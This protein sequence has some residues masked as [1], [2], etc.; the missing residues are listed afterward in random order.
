MTSRTT[1]IGVVGAIVVVVAVLLNYFMAE[2]GP[3]EQATQAPVISRSDTAAVKPSV[4]DKAL[5]VEALGDQLKMTTEAVTDR[6]LPIFDVVRV[7]PEGNTVIAG[8]ARANTKVRILDGGKV[9]GGVTSDGRGDWVFVPTERL[10]PG[11]RVLSL[12]AGNDGLGRSE[13]KEAVVLVIPKPG[14]DIAGSKFIGDR[15]PLA[16]VV[17]RDQTSTA[18]SKL[19]QVPKVSEVAELA[20]ANPNNA[21][22]PKTPLTRSFSEQQKN[23][24]SD[25]DGAK[26]P[27][28]LD[29][30]DYDDKGDVVFSGQAEPGDKVQVYVDNRLLGKTVADAE[31]RWILRP[32]VPVKPG[33]HDIRVDKIAETG[34][35]L[36]R[37]A[38][39]FVRAEPFKALPNQTVVII[40]PGNNLWRIASR[41]YG[42]GLRYTDIFLANADQIRNPDLIYP[43]QVFGLPKSD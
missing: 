35:V 25:T 10:A 39:P 29:T 31:S 28:A 38:L 36:A 34:K 23:T 21:A 19:I 32:T 17:P 33:V 5:G 9:I 13:S 2:Y 22:S 14:E 41:V 18:P 42:D 24:P 7:D 43:G 3:L 16:M 30:V 26:P 11:S 8:R 37:I 6:F 40:Q 12:S 1:I 27:V 15:T 4:P 20:N